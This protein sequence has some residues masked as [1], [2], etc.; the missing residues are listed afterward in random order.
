MTMTTAK[1]L[2]LAGLAA[3]SFGAGAVQ[4]Q[5]VT[6]NPGR[7]TWYAT[8][9][10]AAANNTRGSVSGSVQSGSSDLERSHPVFH[11]DSPD[12]GGGF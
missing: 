11:F 6:P 7:A 2:M 1:T 10:R 8:Q 4:A 5:S 12:V 3:M 9:N